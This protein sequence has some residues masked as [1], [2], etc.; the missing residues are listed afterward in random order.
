MKKLIKILLI[1]VPLVLIA[2]A[3]TSITQL[4]RIVKTTVETMATKVL[5]APVTLDHVDISIFSGKGTISGLEVGNPEGFETERAL[6]LGG[7]DIELDMAS[8]KTDV[9][10]IK[11]ITVNAPEITVEGVKGKNLKQLRANAEAYA[12]KTGEAGKKPEPVEEDDV[13]GKKVVI[14][15]LTITDGRVLYAPVM[16]KSI[17]ISL[18]DYELTDLGGKS[19]GATGAE[20]MGRVLS[21]LDN[22]ALSVVLAAGDA[23][24]DAVGEVAKMGGNLF[25][26]GV[27]A[28]GDAAG[29]GMGAVAEGAGAVLSTADA[30]NENAA[31]LLGDAGDGLEEGTKKLVEGLT[32]LLGGGGDEEPTK[33]EE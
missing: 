4:N 7:L 14:D 9:I 8:L 10:H 21:Q 23:V 5:Q 15:K 27:S 29:S 33:P 17:P 12:G 16:G 24:T 32:G 22:A 31:E 19:G 2:L 25:V 30:A 6:M 11:S 3:V 28:V 1:V 18:G 26:K 20:V 13:Q